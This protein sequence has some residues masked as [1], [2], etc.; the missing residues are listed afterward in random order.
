MIVEQDNIASCATEQKLG[1]L[2]RVI[3]YGPSS[4]ES[5]AFV[6]KRGDLLGSSTLGSVGM[7]WII[8]MCLI[9][10]VDR[11]GGS[12]LR[13]MNLGFTLGENT[14]R[15][16]GGLAGVRV[17]GHILSSMW[18]FLLLLLGICCE[19]GWLF[20]LVLGLGVVVAHG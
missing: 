12:N 20:A 4:Q 9:S 6:E 11:L 15:G 10:V 19:E 18:S 1:F 5:V 17:G 16:V 8:L 3:W 2:L 7:V 13:A 14:G